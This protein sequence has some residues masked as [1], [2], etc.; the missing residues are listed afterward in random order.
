MRVLIIPVS[1]LQT[2]ISADRYKALDYAN[3]TSFKFILYQV[4]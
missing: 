4:L 3:I 1:G 2:F